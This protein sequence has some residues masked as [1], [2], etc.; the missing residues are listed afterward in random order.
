MPGVINGVK[1]NEITMQ[2]AT[3]DLA[4]D[5]QNPIYFLTRKCCMEKEANFDISVVTN[6]FAKH[7]R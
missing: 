6:L 2:H 4:P 5:G 1:A 7:L 3:K